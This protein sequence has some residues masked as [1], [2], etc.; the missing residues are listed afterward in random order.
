M[1]NWSTFFLIWGGLLI[2]LGIFNPVDN[3]LDFIIYK[4][5]PVLVG[6]GLIIVSYSTKIEG[7]AI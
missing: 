3:V 4:L 1:E 6:I 5:V 2:V 7:L